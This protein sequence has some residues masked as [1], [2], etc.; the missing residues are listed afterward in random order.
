MRLHVRAS[1]SSLAACS[2]CAC[3][4]LRKP[5][6]KVARRSQTRTASRYLV[7]TIGTRRFGADAM[8]NDGGQ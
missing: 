1:S 3:C 2:G 4:F 5:G 8:H 6:R 7:F